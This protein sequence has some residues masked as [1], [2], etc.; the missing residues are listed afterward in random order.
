MAGN[1]TLRALNQTMRAVLWSGIPYNLTVVN[2]PIPAIQ[3]PT[4]VRI[5][6]TTAGICGGDLH[7]Y[8]GSFGS[9]T[10]PWVL[11]HEGVGIIESIGDGVQDL[12]VGDHVVIPDIFHVGH[13]NLE[14]AEPETSFG[15]GLGLGIDYGSS[16]GCQSEYVVVPFADHSLWRIPAADAGNTTKEL[17]YLMNADMFATGWA[18]LDFSGFE[19][20]DTVAIFG[21]GP[22]GLL[23]AY[24]A[25]LRGASRVYIVDHVPHRL[26]MA[27]SIGAIPI[28]LNGTAE[29]PVEQIL[30][31]EP[32]GVTRSVDC[33]GYEAVNSNLEPQADRVILDMVAVTSVR[34][35]LGVVGLYNSPDS[36]AGTPRGDTVARS[37]TFPI[38]DFFQKG[39]SMKSGPV[40]AKLHASYLTQLVESG[41]ASPG[42]V[43][44]SVIDIEDAPEYYSRY[45]QYL[46]SKIVIRFP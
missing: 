46:E 7:V 9:T 36:T 39:L 14:L 41:K 5:R 42:F 38:A 24:S 43:V 26:Q 45:S 22:V 28:S 16:G 8:H 2:V 40:D 31:L 32:D 17:D 6:M 15:R 18:A 20:G 37:M 25:I 21:A 19:A 29:G 35:G 11:G 10:P 13:M 3:A 27:E 34:G 23:A 4:D 44:S 1:A 30:R 33:V 12:A